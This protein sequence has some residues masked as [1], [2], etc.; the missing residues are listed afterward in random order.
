MNRKSE[1]QVLND[2]SPSI[3]VNVANK[4]QVI[5]ARLGLWKLQ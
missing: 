2:F 5:L 4:M 3:Q 1:Q